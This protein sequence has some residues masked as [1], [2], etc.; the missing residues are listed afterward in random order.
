MA[1]GNLKASYHGT[2]QVKTSLKTY[3][4]IRFITVVSKTQGIAS[5]HSPLTINQ[6]LIT[7]PTPPA[8]ATE[9]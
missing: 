3:A 5:L 9:V 1:H 2:S 8:L 4:R 7:N 6:Q